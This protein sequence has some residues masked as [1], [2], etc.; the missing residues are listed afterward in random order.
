MNLRYAAT[1][2]PDKNIEALGF[3]REQYYVLVLFLDKNRGTEF[4]SKPSIPTVRNF[5]KLLKL[6]VT[7]SKSKNP[8]GIR[9]IWAGVAKLTVIMQAYETFI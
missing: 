9:A 4:Y 2:Y 5:V 1:S 8:P 3:T 7:T 6:L